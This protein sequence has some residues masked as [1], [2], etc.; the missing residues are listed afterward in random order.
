MGDI[1]QQC[2]ALHNQ[3]FPDSPPIADNDVGRATIDEYINNPFVIELKNSELFADKQDIEIILRFLELHLLSKNKRIELKEII[4]RYVKYFQS[5]DI[6]TDASTAENV[7]STYLTSNT[8]NYDNFNIYINNLELYK[9]IAKNAGLLYDYSQSIFYITLNYIAIQNYI[10]NIDGR[11]IDY[12]TIGIRLRNNSVDH[13]KYV[14]AIEQNDTNKLADFNNRILNALPNTR[15]TTPRLRFDRNGEYIRG[16]TYNLGILNA[17][18]NTPNFRARLDDIN[19]NI[20]YPLIKLYK[21]GYY[22]GY[23]FINPY[24]VKYFIDDIIHLLAIKYNNANLATITYGGYDYETYIISALLE[25]F[26]YLYQDILEDPILFRTR[27]NNKIK[28]MLYTYMNRIFDIN[29]GFDRTI[30]N[31][32]IVNHTNLPSYQHIET[33][34]KYIEIFD[35]LSNYYTSSD[36]ESELASDII[37]ANITEKNSGEFNEN[38]CII[39][40][41]VYF[42]NMRTDIEGDVY[43]TYIRFISNLRRAPHSNIRFN[44]NPI[45]YSAYSR[46]KYN[47]IIKI[48]LF[49]LLFA[50]TMII[51]Y[52]IKPYITL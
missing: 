29:L 49:I 1:Y 52:F 9:F 2:I 15:T 47:D 11:D 40:F 21:F 51:L 22:S 23:V 10:K 27:Q 17:I 32:E 46:K 44:R 13:E 16:P 50:V 6:N 38:I 35:I 48:I 14:L 39:A 18:M 7:P 41:I 26:R 30:R 8:L 36:T 24:N 31:A 25:F 43:Q 28:Y 5:E 19:R 4:Q 37:I 42:A 3:L 45:N 34:K 33:I 20:I 12:S